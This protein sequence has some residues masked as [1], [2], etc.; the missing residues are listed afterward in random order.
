MLFKGSTDLT[1]SDVKTLSI[2]AFWLACELSLI[3]TDQSYCQ[4]SLPIYKPWACKWHAFVF[5]WYNSP[6]WVF[7]V[8]VRNGMVKSLMCW[9]VI[10]E[11]C[12]SERPGS[13]AALVDIDLYLSVLSRVTLVFIPSTLRV[14]CGQTDTHS[15][16]EQHHVCT[17]CC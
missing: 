11:R 16:T 13:A 8:D 4:D 9:F 14:S 7:Y 2:A 12:R 1:Q 5:W 10:P 17:L 6:N 15:H 3:R